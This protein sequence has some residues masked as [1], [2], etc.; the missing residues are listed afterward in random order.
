MSVIHSQGDGIF[1]NSV[2]TPRSGPTSIG[3]KG[4]PK[5][6]RG[7]FVR[8]GIKGVPNLFRSNLLL[9][10]SGRPVVRWC[11]SGFLPDS[12]TVYKE[13]IHFPFTNI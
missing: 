8:V 12:W 1:T 2:C 9:L 3:G 13:K 5:G 6:L 11:I 4:L 10:L 7:A